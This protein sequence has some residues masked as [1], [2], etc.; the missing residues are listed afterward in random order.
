MLTPL[1]LKHSPRKDSCFSKISKW[2]PYNAVAAQTALGR[3]VKP[4]YFMMVGVTVTL[5]FF[6]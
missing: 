6:G 4:E 3:A 2:N 5:P 1:G